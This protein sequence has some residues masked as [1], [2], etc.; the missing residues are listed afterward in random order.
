VHPNDAASSKVV[1]PPP[2]SIDC[3]AGWR[4]LFHQLHFP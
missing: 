1:D 3:V 2:R 4:S